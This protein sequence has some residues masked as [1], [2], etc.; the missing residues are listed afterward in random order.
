MFGTGE[1]RNLR[2]MMGS[3]LGGADFEWAKARTAVVGGEQYSNLA[4]KCLLRYLCTIVRMRHQPQLKLAMEQKFIFFP[5]IFSSRD[6]EWL[7]I[8][9]MNRSCV[10]DVPLKVYSFFNFTSSYWLF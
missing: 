10:P 6:F 5:Y 7:Q 1:E 3:A 8:I 4:G 9:L 2:A